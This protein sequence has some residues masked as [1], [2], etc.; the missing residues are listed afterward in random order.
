MDSEPAGSRLRS[1]IPKLIGAGVALLL[2]AWIVWGQVRVSYQWYPVETYR[3]R[4][5]VTSAAVFVVPEEGD[6]AVAS[7]V[8]PDS[9][10][11]LCE[12]EAEVELLRPI[13]RR[14]VGSGRSRHEVDFDRRYRQPSYDEIARA[15]PE[16]AV[17]VRLS[18][19]LTG[20]EVMESLKESPDGNQLLDA[21]NDAMPREIEA[22]IL[23][24]LAENIL[25]Q[26]GNAFLADAVRT[27]G[28][29][30]TQLK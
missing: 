26:S 20:Q 13:R 8:V 28:I 30:P 15:R 6:P 14:R 24:R 25:V 1:L 10:S 7:F 19:R 4:L 16:R 17:I 27:G 11:V 22:R 3:T 9:A 12:V 23:P 21:Y 2:G 18:R 29:P 5:I